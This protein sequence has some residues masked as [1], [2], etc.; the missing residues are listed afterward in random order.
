MNNGTFFEFFEEARWHY[1]FGLTAKDIRGHGGAAAPS[2]VFRPIFQ[3]RSGTSVEFLFEDEVQAASVS[4]WSDSSSG[5]PVFESGLQ[6]FHANRSRIVLPLT[7]AYLETLRATKRLTLRFAIWLAPDAYPEQSI[8][9]CESSENVIALEET[10]WQTEVLPALGYPRVR[11][12][13]LTLDLPDVLQGSSQATVKW[14]KALDELSQVLKDYQAHHVEPRTLVSPLRLAVDHA[15]YA[16]IHLWNLE[17][18]ESKKSDDL[19]KAINA[20]IKPC[21]APNGIIPASVQ[22]SRLCSTLV[23]M[24]DL[25][26]LSNPEQHGGTVGAYTLNDAE[27]ILYLT[28]GILRSLPDLWQAYP[29][30]PA[31]ENTRS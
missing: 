17:V 9:I 20:K 15:L 16:W 30:P 24:H 1:G 23:M 7:V 3:R 6:Y 31:S 2:L 10:H 13:P 29:A 25:L 4:L 11:L 22:H 19:L 8:R 26:Q 12:V 27:T 28:F 21:N 18:P 5:A 14:K